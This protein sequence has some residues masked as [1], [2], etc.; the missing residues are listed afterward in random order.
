[1]VEALVW[2]PVLND[3]AAVFH[4]ATLSSAFMMR[5][6]ASGSKIIINSPDAASK[7]R[8]KSNESFRQTVHNRPGPGLRLTDANWNNSTAYKIENYLALEP[9]SWVLTL[10]KRAQ[11]PAE[12]MIQIL[13]L[14]G[15][16]RI[17]LPQCQQKV[18]SLD[19]HSFAI[20]MGTFRLHDKEFFF[21]GKQH[22]VCELRQDCLL[23]LLWRWTV[24]WSFHAYPNSPTW[25]YTDY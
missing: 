1:M 23:H 9:G 16:C 11:S 12:L 18:F 5:F 2:K 8:G 19:P 24:H 15:P 20:L 13:R 6:T 25:Y 7:L 4:T 10:A 3:Y 14:W 17:L 22:S 21:M